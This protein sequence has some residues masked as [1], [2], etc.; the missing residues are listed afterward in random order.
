MGTCVRATLCHVSYGIR[1]CYLPPDTGERALPSSM[2]GQYSIFLPVNDGTW[3]DLDRWL[4]TTV[5]YLSSVIHPR[6]DNS[7]RATLLIETNAL[8]TAQNLHQY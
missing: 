4:Y 6:S 2:A 1:K 7:C 8:T 3:V 5:F